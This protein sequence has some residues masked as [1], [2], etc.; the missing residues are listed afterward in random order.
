MKPT[1]LSR[2]HTSEEFVLSARGG[3]RGPDE[4]KEMNFMPVGQYKNRTLASTPQGLLPS[5]HATPQGLLP[6]SHALRR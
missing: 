1:T 5:S 6:S 2:L 4:E 3:Q